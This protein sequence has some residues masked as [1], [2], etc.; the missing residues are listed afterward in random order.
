MKTYDKVFLA[1]NLLACA[2]AV[3][4]ASMI[5]GT[6]AFTVVCALLGAVWIGAKMEK[7]FG[8]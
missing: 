2:S 5:S 7:I 6:L 1:G 4:G 3:K 8:K